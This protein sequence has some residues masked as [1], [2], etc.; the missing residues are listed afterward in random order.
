MSNYYE[1]KLNFR[2]KEDIPK[3]ILHDLLLLS[4]EEYSRE[5]FIVLQNEKWG[6]HE[7]YDYP[8][9]NLKLKKCDEHEFYLF[10]ID[11]CM[12]GYR[13]GTDDLGQDIY[14]FLKSYIDESVYDMSDGGYI[15]RI[16]DDDDTYDKNFYVNYDIFKRE[17]E[18]RK[19]LCNADC[20]YHKE[21]CLCDKYVV[22]K[23]AYQLGECDVFYSGRSTRK[24]RKEINGYLEKEPTY[25]PGEEVFWREK[26]CRIGTFEKYKDYAGTIEYDSEDKIHYGKVLFTNENH[27]VNYEAENIVELEEEFH[28][29]VDDYLEFCKEIDLKAE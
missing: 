11:F 18:K 26:T 4:S 9:Y 14:D 7:R 16:H 19:Y 10:E 28:K 27:L 24:N 3:D 13:I 6:R 8:N 12:K 1:G 22:C 2:L 17:I 20:Y 29:A 15:G 21:N 23:R 25:Y 5:N